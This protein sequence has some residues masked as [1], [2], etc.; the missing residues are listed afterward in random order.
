VRKILL[1]WFGKKSMLD[2][3]KYKNL[4]RPSQMMTFIKSFPASGLIYSSDFR[5]LVSGQSR[6]N[7]TVPGNFKS[8]RKTP[9]NVI[10]Y[11]I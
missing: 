6:S 5:Q 1:M 8:F 10:F 2:V 3:R 7:N 4:Q 11:Y 9:S